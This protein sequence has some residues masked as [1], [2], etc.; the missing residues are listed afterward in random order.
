M[1]SRLIGHVVE[2]NCGARERGGRSW[3]AVTVWPLLC[4]RYCVAVTVWPLLGVLL[5][6]VDGDLDVGSGC[7]IWMWNLCLT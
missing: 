4:G 6:D 1:T 2:V 5:G 7:G 3:V